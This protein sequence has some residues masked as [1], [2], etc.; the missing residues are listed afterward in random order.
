MKIMGRYR[1][2]VCKMCRREGQKLYLKGDKCFSDKCTLDRKY[3][4]PGQHTHVRRKFSE[5][6]IRLRE[7]QKARSYYGILE[8]QFRNYFVK[9][10]KQRGVTGETLLVLLE[11]RLDNVVCRLGLASSR[12]EAR[13]LV[14]HG[15]FMVN[16]RKVDIPSYQVNVGDE[17]EV[18]EKFKKSQKMKELA[19]EAEHKTP[20]A[21]LEVDIG[22]LKGRVLALPSREEIDTPVQEHLIVELYSR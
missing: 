11:R 22:N 3:Y 20:P 15:H 2:S 21:W 10:D 12:P 8:K 17:I 1:G 18:S 13:Q 16:G 9:A 5:Y 4:P 14:R 6:G 7:K 19:A